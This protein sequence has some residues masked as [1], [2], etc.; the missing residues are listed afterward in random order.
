MKVLILGDVN[1]AH[2]Q[3]WATGLSLKGITVAIWSLT[4]SKADWYSNCDIRLFGQ[5]KAGRSS[6]LS[7]FFSHQSAKKALKEFCP[8]ILHAHYASSYGLIGRKL[9]FQPFFISVWGSDITHFPKGM[10]RRLL[11]Q[12]NLTS[13]NRIFATSQYLGDILR[14]KWHRKSTII[15][16]GIDTEKFSPGKINHFFKS[17]EIVFGTVKALESVYRIDLVIA[18]F[19]QL[20]KNRPELPLRLLI[21]GEGSQKNKLIQQVKLCGIESLVKFTGKIPHDKIGDVHR[22]INVFMN[23][24]KSESFGVS[25]LEASSCAKPVI[26]SAVGGLL[27]VVKNGETGYLVNPNET[28]KVADLMERLINDES[29]RMQLGTAGRAFVKSN[30]DWD[31]NLEEMINAYN[32]TVR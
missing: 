21:V 14:E 31:R 19:A 2:I 29:L 9:K 10:V 15:P 30:Y 3:R 7:Y 23:F 25:V 27:E 5:Q 13:A 6:K 12:K 18:A 32:N 22:E 4:E 24:S 16:F 1:S 28:E 26:V 8:D 20:N 11:M 17:G